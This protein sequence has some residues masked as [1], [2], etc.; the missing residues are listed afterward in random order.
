ML[1]KGDI[2]MTGKG[3]SVVFYEVIRV[4]KRTLLIAELE[5]DFATEDHGKH[6]WIWPKLSRKVYGSA[7]ACRIRES[8]MIKIG[9]EFAY[10]WDGKPVA[11]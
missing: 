8:G 11:Y 7:R 6:G 5:Q 2:L 9:V 3:I 4:M 1:Q 10:K